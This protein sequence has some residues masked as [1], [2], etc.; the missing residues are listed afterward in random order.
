MGGHHV[1]EGATD[2]HAVRDLGDGLDMG[3]GGDAEAHA[4]G[5]GGVLTDLRH[6]R[7]QVGG[8]FGAL[9]GDAFTGHVVDEAGGVLGDEADT[10]RGRGRGH[11][12]DIG[13]AVQLAGGDEITG[14]FWWAIQDQ[15]AIAT[16]FA[17]FAA[18]VLD[19]KRE[20]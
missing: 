12:K 4:D 15:Q 6:G 18:V 8:Q 14:L 1:H 3:G 11:D 19:A 17:D 7:S 9:S 10:G 16:G 20:E 5:Q 2:D 13:E